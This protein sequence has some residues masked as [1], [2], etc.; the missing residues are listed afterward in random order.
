MLVCLHTTGGR[1]S[2]RQFAINIVRLS[3]Q[4]YKS[5]GRQFLIAI[6]MSSLRLAVDRSELF[7]NYMTVT[8]PIYRSAVDR[9]AILYIE[10][11]ILYT[12]TQYL[13]TTNLPTVYLPSLVSAYKSTANLLSD[14]LSS[15]HYAVF[16]YR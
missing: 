13:S 11:V 14:D 10:P 9:S 12:Y 4:Y 3:C 6:A 1:Y 7:K 15:P 2:G 5:V 16:V 8:S